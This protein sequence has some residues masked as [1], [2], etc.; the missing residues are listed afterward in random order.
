MSSGGS[1][2][3]APGTPPPIDPLVVGTRFVKQ[4]YSILLKTPENLD[5]FYQKSS[6]LSS[7]IGSDPS[8]LLEPDDAK[9]RFQNK[10]VPFDFDIGAID[11]QLSMNGGVLLVVTGTLVED[12]NKRTNFVHTFFLGSL[13]SGSKRS[14][15]IH[16]DILRF[17]DDDGN[18]NNKKAEDEDV[19]QALLSPEPGLT[20]VATMEPEPLP[21]AEV[22]PVGTPVK[23]QLSNN[24]NNNHHDKPEP[25]SATPGNGV[26]ETKEVYETDDDKPPGSWA[27][28][29]TRTNKTPVSSP[30]RPE[31]PHHP[32][33]VVVDS[34]PSKTI[35]NSKPGKRD[36]ECTLVCKN[37]D[38]AATDAQVLDLF[39]P[40]AKTTASTIIGISVQGH[41]GIAF[42]D[43]DSPNPVLAAVKQHEKEP[44][45]IHDKKLDV[46][47]KTLEQKA[48][49]SAGRGRGRSSRRGGRGRGGRGGR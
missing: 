17:L 19:P 5:M 13:T 23:E 46:Y 27:A 40:F 6:V 11:A 32:T 34:A 15:Y 9:A 39:Q 33:T 22:Q 37:V 31:K 42:V 8:T 7:G 20:P 30:S 1:T 18:K 48:R 10:N 44:F 25:M 49:K 4:Y 35:P 41:R 21:P 3:R 45:V 24:N 28:M 29:V 26:E 38:A 47:Q 16:N 36:P 2:P 12:G 43:Y 14:F